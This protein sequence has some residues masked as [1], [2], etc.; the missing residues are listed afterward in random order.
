MATIDTVYIPNVFGRT[1][2]P[3][4]HQSAPIFHKEF[5]ARSNLIIDV[6]NDTIKIP[7]H[8]F[9]T[10]EKL[11]YSIPDLGS[12]IGISTLSPGANGTISQLPSTVYPIV[13]DKDRIRVALASS[14]AL[15]NSYVDITSLG[16]ESPHTFTC[17]KQNAKCLISID[18]VI[19]SPVSVG[20]SVG[21]TS[22]FDNNST[23]IRI[24]SIDNIKLG[25]IL[26]INE[27][28]SRVT[29]IDYTYN[30]SPDGYD[31]N[32]YRNENF[33]GT[34]NAQ[35]VGVQ[36]A[37]IMEGNYNIEKDKIYF[38][39]A[40]LEGVEFT[41]RLETNSL[42]YGTNSFELFTSKLDTGSQVILY[43]VNPPNGLEN[44]KSYFLIKNYTNNYSFA[45]SYSNAING[46][47][48][49]FST[50]ALDGGPVS[51]IDLV[52]VLPIDNSSF[53]GRVFL[54]SNYDGNLVFDDVS[55]QFN[56][57]SSSF[58]LTSSGINTVGIKSDNGIVLINNI[59]QYPEFDESFIFEEDS[60]SG[61]TSISFIGNNETGILTSKSYDTNIS[62]YPRG[63]IIVG[64][65]LSS[66]INYQ[67]LRSASAN[68]GITP[69][70]TIN[71]VGI[72]TG[73]SGYRSGISTYYVYFEDE[74]GERSSALGVANVSSGIVTSVTIVTNVPEGTYSPSQAISV[75]IDPPFPY[76]NVPVSGSTLGIGASVSFNVGEDGVIKN[77]K[78]T[79]PGYG[80]T[81]GETLTIPNTLGIST[82][83]SDDRAKIFI[84]EVTKDSFSAWNI[85]ILRKLDDLTPFVTGTRKTFTLKETI[86]SVS[87]TISIQ[88][89][90][91]SEID[92]S[93]VLLIFVND[94]LQIPG[95][96]Y[97]FNGGSQIT[98]TEAPPAKLTSE[99]LLEKSTVKVY[100][101]A[102]YNPD[103]EEVSPN[104]NFKV[105]DTVLIPK[106]LYETSP[107]RQSSR[108]VKEILT[109]DSF[110]TELFNGRGLS[111]D[112]GQLRSI[113]WTP[114]KND[115]IIS[116]NYV[117]KSR[118]LYKATAGIYTGI[119]Q[120]TATF[121]GVSTVGI[122][123]TIG[124]GISIGDYIE[125]STIGY[126]ISIV[127]IGS[128]YVGISTYD[129]SI[130]GI[131]TVKI[132]RYIFD[133]TNNSW[134]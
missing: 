4:R 71:T 130:V 61:I 131:Q 52:Q 115:L 93:Y 57:I 106:D 34:P 111:D 38:T 109:S 70:G 21:I 63:G 51:P 119:G 81:S 16:T 27:E 116:G 60:V 44:N 82:Q 2:F 47:S 15:E 99:G 58:T 35:I 11:T 85:G 31:I 26:K 96:S 134:A 127:S 46:I 43:S 108:T 22:V 59:F 121:T 100:F 17:D 32:L 13:V 80:Y 103:T 9:K 88:A 14:L 79:N 75:R 123:T 33:L 117:S 3:L 20:S 113:N 69:E 132:W 122:N 18:N 74:D 24:N 95:K 12:R 98:F 97:T 64:Y 129:P 72:I 126:G 104:T 54:K 53:H 23:K 76:E 94:V 89:A 118:N 107:L 19:Q 50:P 41:A 68:C 73:G 83:S 84:S 39:S 91:D 55:Q 7:N 6:D 8:F 48:L 49:V 5:D 37:Y 56:G 62:G 102:G 133:A 40:P 114:Q 66:G 36:T 86:D 77:F 25:T 110:K 45:N 29:S 87:Q 10:G 92:L 78:F 67:P 128:S 30:T 28:L 1:S 65:A 112:S 120:T 90:D 101:Y 125:S 105:G 42:N 124:I